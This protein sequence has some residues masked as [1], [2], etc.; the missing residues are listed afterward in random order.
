MLHVVPFD[1]IEISAARGVILDRVQRVRRGSRN[2][3]ASLDGFWKGHLDASG[4]RRLPFAILNSVPDQGELQARLAFS[5]PE[6]EPVSLRLLEASASAY[7]VVTEAYKDPFTGQL[8]LTSLEGRWARNR[9]WGV[10]LTRPFA[11]G[12]AAV[13]EFRAV[14]AEVA[15]WSN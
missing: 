15:G 8:V 13:G 12:P 2:P 14:R 6:A 11:G 3:I 4:E 7:V 5:F 1:S 10:Y 9:M